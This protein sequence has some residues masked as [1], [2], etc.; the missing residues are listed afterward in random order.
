ML[1]GIAAMITSLT[2]VAVFLWTA[3]SGRKRNT[4]EH[5]ANRDKMQTLFDDLKETVLANHG[6]NAVRFNTLTVNQ[7]IMFGMV[8]DLDSKISQVAELADNARE[9]DSRARKAVVVRS[10]DLVGV[11]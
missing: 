8:A 2:G 9:A 10:K 5:E 11:R 4:L 7:D 6:E 1:L 3:W